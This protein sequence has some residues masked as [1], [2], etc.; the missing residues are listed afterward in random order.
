MTT[1]RRRGRPSIPKEVQRQRLIDAALRVLEKTHYEKTSVADIVREARMS[2][3][4]FYDQFKSKEDLIAEIVEEKARHFFEQLQTK[5]AE[6][7][8]ATERVSGAIR[9][10]LELF[11]VANV[12]LE[13][14]GSEAGQRVRE[15]RRHYVQ[16]LTDINM[17]GLEGLYERGEIARVPPRATMEFLLTG[18]EGM[19][20]R[21]YS[22]GRREELLALHPVLLTVFLRALGDPSGPKR[23]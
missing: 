5:L 7:R 13:R 16:L 3:R 19:S 20:F 18:I 15:V 2:S 1:Q 10:Y 23:P 14:L 21:Y 8:S 17:R 9:A 4:S 6:P 11:P 22:E 12:D